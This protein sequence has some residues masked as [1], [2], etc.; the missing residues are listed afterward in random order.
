MAELRL[1]LA[2]VKPGQISVDILKRRGGWPV[3]DVQLPVAQ[4]TNTEYRQ[5]DEVQHHLEVW[6]AFIQQNQVNA[7]APTA[8]PEDAYPKDSYEK[9]GTPT[10]IAAEVLLAQHLKVEPS[11]ITTN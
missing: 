8:Y 5:S 1:A 10:Q 6:R 7:G 4:I 2:N 11:S 3:H 9:S